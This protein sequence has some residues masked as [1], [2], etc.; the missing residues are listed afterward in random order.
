MAYYLSSDKRLKQNFSKCNEK[1]LDAWEDISWCQ[2]KFKEDVK[3]Y[4]DHARINTGL[5][6]QDLHDVFDKHKVSYKDYELTLH[7][8]QEEEETQYD[9]EGNIICEAQPAVDEWRIDY[10]QALS[11]E[12]A[13]QRRRA[14]R[15]EARIAVL[16]ERLAKLETALLK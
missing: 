15:A 14:S 2:F 11:I 8:T 5:V 1:L 16:E 7:Y 13:Y 4:G 9:E 12:A 3:N 6:V 10:T